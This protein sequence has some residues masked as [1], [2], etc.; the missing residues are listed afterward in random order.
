MLVNRYMCFQPEKDLVKVIQIKCS[1]LQNAKC[2]VEKVEMQRA[3]LPDLFY[4]IMSRK[5]SGSHDHE[6]TAKF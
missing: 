3:K 5:L 1:F 6:K 4:L 2:I